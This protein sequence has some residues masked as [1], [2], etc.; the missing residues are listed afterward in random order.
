MPLSAQNHV[1]PLKPEREAEL[2]PFSCVS[3]ERKGAP[4]YLFSKQESS[5]CR[6]DLVRCTNCEHIQIRNWPEQL[7]IKH[8]DYYL[9]RLGADR[10]DRYRE[11]NTL[12]QKEL[13]TEFGKRTSGRK[14]LDVG[15][16]EG[17]FVYT[18]NQNGWKA[19]GIDL[20]EPAIQ[21]CKKFGANARSIDFF[22]A[23]LDREKFDV[24][25]MSELIEHVPHP[26][27]FLKRAEE[28]LLAGGFLY[29]T[30]PNFRSLTERSLRQNWSAIS[31]QHIS[32]F[33]PS[34]FKRLVQSQTHFIV[35]SLITK[36]LS[37][38][39]ILHVLRSKPLNEL[40][41]RSGEPSKGRVTDQ[42]MRERMM[43]SK[44]LKLLMKLA[45][46]FLNF[47]GLGDT[48]VAVLTKK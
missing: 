44:P 5:A 21:L 38:G 23:E 48:M 19:L 8:Y 16:G 37:V 17:Q 1:E 41:A 30:T 22:S 27:R 40:P 28:L 34:S 10:K 9:N 47:F 26:G 32:Y 35:S 36:N 31:I 7:E 24:I 25:V 42:V 33:Y 43:R 11:I 2:N 18:A 3:C 4:N 6:L 46:S 20:S 13:L 14:I 29:L 15:C 45:N 12:R 39:S